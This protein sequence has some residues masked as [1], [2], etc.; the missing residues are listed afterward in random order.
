MKNPVLFLRKIKE[1]GAEIQ[2]IKIGPKYFVFVF[3]P[4]IASQSARPTST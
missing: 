2:R 4:D 3:N 1:T